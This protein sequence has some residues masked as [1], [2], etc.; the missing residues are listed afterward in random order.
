MSYSF[1]FIIEYK[2][3]LSVACIHQESNRRNS[4]NIN[5]II[6]PDG[7]CS[8]YNDI[9]ENDVL[10]VTYR[11]SQVI[12]IVLSKPSVPSI[13]P[14]A[15]SSVSSLQDINLLQT[16][17]QHSTKPLHSFFHSFREVRPSSLS[18]NLSLFIS[19]IDHC[20]IFH[21]QEIL[22]TLWLLHNKLYYYISQDVSQ[23]LS[24]QIF[25]EISQILK[26]P[27]ETSVKLEKITK[28]YQEKKSAIEILMSHSVKLAAITGFHKAGKGLSGRDLITIINAADSGTFELSDFIFLLDL[29]KVELRVIESKDLSITSWGK[30]NDLVVALFKTE[31][32]EYIPIYSKQATFLSKC[33]SFEYENALKFYS[34]L[35][36]VKTEE[37]YLKPQVSKKKS[38]YSKLAQA[39]RNLLKHESLSNYKPGDIPPNLI[40]SNSD[41]LC[42][43][44]RVLTKVAE[45]PCGHF[46]CKDCSGQ[47]Y[48]DR[49]YI[50]KICNF[51]TSPEVVL[52]QYS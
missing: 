13:P 42:S 35:N 19:L 50:C 36:P 20:I 34:T 46:F 45:Y 28:I 3:H 27:G 4:I 11:D 16:L 43:I 23:V 8:T 22:E 48:N 39:L 40:K 14:L 25:Q 51:C 32:S 6:L 26:N 9:K 12:S 47:S 31:N 33:N 10:T 38:S 1:D 37:D 2:D 5:Q 17:N 52:S 18:L 29:L 24:L 49:F 7:R 41:F 30:Y 21:S 44:C 15:S